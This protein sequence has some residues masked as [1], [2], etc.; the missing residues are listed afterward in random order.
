MVSEETAGMNSANSAPISK[1]KFVKKKNDVK[2][3]EDFLNCKQCGRKNHTICVL[4]K[5]E[6]WKDFV[7][8][9]CLNSCGK[10]RRENKFRAANLPECE[11]SK[12]IETRVNSHIKAHDKNHEA[13]HV[14]IRVVFI[15]EKSVETRSGIRKEGRQNNLMMPEK[16]KYKAKALFAF[17][18]IDNNDVCFFGLHVQEYNDKCQDQNKRRV[19]IGYLDSVKFFKPAALRTEVYHELLISKS[20][21][22][23]G[24]RIFLLNKTI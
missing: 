1:D 2:D 23:S 18:V 7:C 19:Y 17:E 14:Y 11:L 10:K 4:H 22:N 3:P 12:H 5:K 15:G 24:D 16:Y 8:D 21:I 6:I 13:G 9:K 20:Y